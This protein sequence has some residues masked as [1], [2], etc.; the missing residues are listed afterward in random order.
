GLE[1]EV[2]QEAD[3]GEVERDEIPLAS[4]IARFFKGK[5][6]SAPA[7]GEG[8]EPAKRETTTTLALALRD[9]TE[10]RPAPTLGDP[11]L[12]AVSGGGLDY[13]YRAPVPA[14]IP[15]AGKEIRIPLTAQTFR[16]AAFY[17]ATPA[18]AATAFL[19]ARVRNDGTRPLLR[20]PVAIFGDGE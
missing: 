10:P 6:K 17:E 19:R 20:G 11:Y 3:E 1:R 14:S 2:V 8:S 18:L 15:S 12:P 4:R 9:V 16:A 7:A 13:V 5:R